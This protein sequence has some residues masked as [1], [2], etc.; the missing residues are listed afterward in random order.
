[1]ASGAAVS[2]PAGEKPAG[3]AGHVM[4]H[5]VVSS[6]ALPA[7]TT[8]RLAVPPTAQTWTRPQTAVHAPDLTSIS[9]SVLVITNLSRQLGGV[10][11]VHLPSGLPR[12]ADPAADDQAWATNHTKPRHLLLSSHTSQVPSWRL[13]REGR[14]SVLPSLPARALVS[15]ADGKGEKLDHL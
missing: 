7:T 1:M 12:N 3:R 15:R 6:S 9:V 13:K 8:S 11:P 10:R 2:V 4:P 5:V 14:R